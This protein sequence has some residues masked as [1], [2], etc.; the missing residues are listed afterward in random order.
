MKLA[1]VLLSAL[2]L[3]STDCRYGCD[4]NCLSMVSGTG[5]MTGDVSTAHDTSVCSDS[6]C[7]TVPITFDA[8]GNALATY[9]GDVTGTLDITPA[10]D[11]RLR[12]TGK[13]NGFNDGD[14]YGLLV[15]ATGGTT[16]VA[17]TSPNVTYAETHA[18]G[19]SC[20]QAFF[21]F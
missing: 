7:S 8:K 1:S 10:G 18:C 13:A 9:V 12:V 11:I 17:K 6:A 15:N 3:A 21:T 16:L 20:K 19:Y 4:A 5:T 2:A 14:V